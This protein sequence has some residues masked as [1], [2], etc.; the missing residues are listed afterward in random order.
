M[1][2]ADKP[3]QSA[4]SP[5][6]SVCPR[7]LSGRLGKNQSVASAS[8]RRARSG[9][10]APPVRVGTPASFSSAATRRSDCFRRPVPRASRT[11]SSRASA[12][13]ARTVWQVRRAAGRCSMGIH[14]TAGA[15]GTLPLPA[16][17]RAQPAYPSGQGFACDRASHAPGREK[18]AVISSNSASLVKSRGYWVR[19]AS[20][21]LSTR[22]CASNRLGGQDVERLV[23]L[24]RAP[25]NVCDNNA[26][27]LIDRDL[28]WTASHARRVQCTHPRP[29][30]A[31]A[32][33]REVD[34]TVVEEGIDCRRCGYRPAPDHDAVRRPSVCRACI[35]RGNYSGKN[36]AEQN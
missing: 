24:R 30:H 6:P 12:A 13:A 9:H 25:I 5:F 20:T 10:H 28:L 7:P 34:C 26:Y 36:R 22:P 35:M 23:K 27:G 29:D 1:E 8:A 18:C 33:P 11:G 19:R 14:H 3:G 16:A 2:E 32:N 17:P 21:A 31:H 15:P 4:D